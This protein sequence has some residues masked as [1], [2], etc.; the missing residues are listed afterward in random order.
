M[1]TRGSSGIISPQTSPRSGHTSWGTYLQWVDCRALELTPDALDALFREEAGLWVSRG[2]QFGA[3]GAGFVRLNI[4]TQR[5]R[6]EE[7]LDALRDA[8]S[9]QTR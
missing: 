1:K 2:D 8:L 4:A 6:L 5:V 9:K 3:E 7:A